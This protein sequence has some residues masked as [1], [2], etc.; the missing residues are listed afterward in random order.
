MHVVGGGDVV[1]RVGLTA[2][3]T[4]GVPVDKWGTASL[5]TSKPLHEIMV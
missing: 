2:L 3:Q 5:Q 4:M 1:T